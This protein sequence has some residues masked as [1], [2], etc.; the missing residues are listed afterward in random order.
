M[1]GGSE[2]P[3]LVAGNAA[4]SYVWELVE[5]DEMPEKRDP[6]SADEKRALRD[7]ID[8]GAVIAS[9]S[10]DPSAHRLAKRP[11]NYTR[12]LTNS[13]YIETVRASVG[14]DIAAQARE[15]LPP[16]LRADGFSNTAYNM[17][18]DLKHIEAYAQLAEIIVSK[19]DIAAFAA[20]FSKN[21]S[22]TQKPFRPHIEKMGKWLLRGPLEDPEIDL[23]H[24]ISTSISAAGG[25]FDDAVRHIV[26][27]M[28]QSPRFIYRAGRGGGSYGAP[29]GGYEVASRLSY[30][31]W[32]GPPDAELLRA[33]DKG[34]LS[35]ST[36]IAGQVARMLKGP[37][38]VRRSRE[39]VAEWLHL[40]RLDSMAPSKNLY[41]KWDPALGRDMREETLAFFEEVV[42]TK[43]RPMADLLNAQV[44]LATPDLARHYG[45]DPAT[46][47]KAG[48]SLLRFDLSGNPSRG[49]LLTQGSILTVGGDNASM[50][51]RGLFV[52]HDLLRAAVK[53][54]PPGTDTTPVASKPGFSQRR[55]SEVRMSDKAC[56]GCHV[57]FE[58]LAFALERYDG[59]GAY[60]I[61]DS[62]GND[63]HQE[64]EI[65]LPGAAVPAKY[66]TTGELMDILANSERVGENITWKIAQFVLG[67]PL[68]TSDRPSL[69]KV[70]RE[71]LKNGGTYA[72]VIAALA[73][74]DLI[75]MT[76]SEPAGEQK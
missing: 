9:E 43:R 48:G 66:N 57:K 10:I 44:T 29:T 14:V 40:D 3:A 69:T 64:G 33:A 47:Q 13:E 12:R 27:A 19:M 38:A 60:H 32:G 25:D 65:L 62:F 54:P 7:W 46:G 68:A 74:S 1:A 2:G 18:V 73:T 53:D 41:P 16:E 75:R 23:F 59:V 76:P 34:E 45:L 70:H 52:L 37:R 56:G 8:S 17:G 51:T 5:S 24:G 15:L 11:T 4:K 67:R 30:M 42:W 36:K 28:L 39:F 49:G 20:R 6:L 50:V 71:A 31:V 58:P 21:R 26:Q 61:Q 22:L 63:L 35:D 55:I 72:A